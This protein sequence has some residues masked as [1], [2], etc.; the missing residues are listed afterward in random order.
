MA[1]KQRFLG[2]TRNGL[3]NISGAQTTETNFCFTG[4]IPSFMRVHA[5]KFFTFRHFMVVTGDRACKNSTRSIPETGG[6][7]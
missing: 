1:K 6:I 5:K 3:A 4:C 2:G 7:I